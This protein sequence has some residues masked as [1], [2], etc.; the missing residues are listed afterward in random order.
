[1]IASLYEKHPFLRESLQLQ[2]PGV[3][4][5]SVLQVKLFSLLILRSHLAIP[6]EIRVGDDGMFAPE[7]PA[8]LST[9][10]Q[11]RATYRHIAEM[12]HLPEEIADAAFD[13][14]ADAYSAGGRLRWR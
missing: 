2:V 10:D 8:V 3:N 5:Q 9:I 11:S 14:W 1:V 6:R 7:V 13:K 4:T 12:V